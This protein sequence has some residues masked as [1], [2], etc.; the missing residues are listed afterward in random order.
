MTASLK[1][2]VC[3]S[4]YRSGLLSLAASVLEP[5]DQQ[6]GDRPFQILIYHRVGDDGDA[7]VPAVSTSGFEHHMRCLREHFHPM[8]L[9]DLLV[10][11][12]RR[13]VPAR[14]VAVTF[15]DGYLDV[16]R[17]G[18]PILQR[19]AI[20]S[21][22]YVATAFMDDGASMWNDRIG[23]A[24]RATKHPQLDG[25]GNL[26]PLSL[27]TEAERRSAAQRV[28]HALKRQPPAQRDA[29]TAEVLRRL[30][31]SADDAPPMLRWQ[32]VRALHDAGV[33]VGAHTVHHPIL[34][35][36]PAAEAAAEIRDSKLAIEDHLQTAV[37]H[38]A[39]PNGTVD[40]FDAS[41][42]AHVEQAG[43]TSAVSTVFGVNTAA[44]DRFALR[45][46]GPWEE[47]A[48]VFSVKLWWYRWRDSGNE[49]ADEAHP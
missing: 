28:T 44:S 48:G 38:F 31:A 22:I 46:G 5:P 42:R 33:E 16:L 39:Y 34:S 3:A 8:S 19:Y 17:H 30:D 23:C 20:P 9:S 1:S 12:A 10:A 27:R 2:A 43:F 41:T 6:P 45:R 37:P 14:A 47:D 13:E 29:S 4:L 18:L 49:R 35:A 26:E 21:T 15:D 36:L 24:L 40:D 32:Q 25:I 7:Y 11:A